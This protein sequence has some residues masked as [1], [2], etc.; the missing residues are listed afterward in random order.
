MFDALDA[1]LETGVPR[2]ALADAGLDTRH[3]EQ[4]IRG[5]AHAEAA[6][7][8]VRVAFRAP[9]GGAAL[10]PDDPHLVRLLVAAAALAGLA[11]AAS[12]AT[13]EH[14]ALVTLERAVDEAFAYALTTRN[15]A[16]WHALSTAA[17]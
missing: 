6:L 17:A 13:P 7:E 16:I 10:A 12:L 14:P 2:T 15:R 1:V 3:V 11:R 5:F 9:D 4:W 8:A